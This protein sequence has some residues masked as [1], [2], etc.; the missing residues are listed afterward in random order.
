M[1]QFEYFNRWF[2]IN[3]N[4]QDNNVRFYNTNYFMIAEFEKEHLYIVLSLDEPGKTYGYIHKVGINFIPKNFEDEQLLKE[5]QNWYDEIIEK[6]HLNNFLN[7]ELKTN[8]EFIN[9]KEKV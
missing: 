8:N 2:D 4:S 5:I 7:K 3:C 1:T 6:W 9:K